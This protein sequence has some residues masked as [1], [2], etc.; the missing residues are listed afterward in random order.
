MGDSMSEDNSMVECDLAKVEVAGSN[1]VPRSN[2]QKRSSINRKLKRRTPNSWRIVFSL[3]IKEIRT[4]TTRK[5]KRIIRAITLYGSEEIVNKR[6]NE[7]QA[8]LKKFSSFEERD[9]FL[10][11]IFGPPLFEKKPYRREIK[12]GICPICLKEK[13]LFND[14]CHE[15]GLDRDKICGTC[16]SGIGFF[17]E[18]IDALFRAIQ[19]ISHHN[20]VRSFFD[21]KYASYKTLMELQNENPEC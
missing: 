13:K 3:G 8:V 9:G 14:H 7:I 2:I 1:P 4:K 12:L 6:V 18:D 15:S 16:N 11:A 20:N 19:Y 17:K 10:K 5:R 21:T